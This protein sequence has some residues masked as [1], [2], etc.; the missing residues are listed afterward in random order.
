MN[1]IEFL[2]GDFLIMVLLVGALA[3]WRIGRVTSW[4]ALAMTARATGSFTECV[5]FI[6]FCAEER[7]EVGT[8][9]RRNVAFG[10]RT[11][12]LDELPRA[13]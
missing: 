7:S 2:A 12:S 9:R 6:R 3:V 1:L 13:S 8:G 5:A 10:E 11:P 4:R